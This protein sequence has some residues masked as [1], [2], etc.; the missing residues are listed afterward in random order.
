MSVVASWR[1][2]VRGI[3]V[4]Y[5]TEQSTRCLGE[6][7]MTLKCSQGL[8]WEQFPEHLQP[9]VQMLDRSPPVNL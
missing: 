7:V 8:L 5:L 6:A 4:Q 9:P 2:S 3:S 1:S